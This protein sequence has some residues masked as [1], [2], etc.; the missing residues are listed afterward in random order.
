[1]IEQKKSTHKVPAMSV[2]ER[3]IEKIRRDLAPSDIEVIDESALHAGHAQAPKGGES[4][5]R[6]R[7]VSK[8]FCGLNRIQRQRLIHDILGPELAGPIHALSIDA[9][10]PDE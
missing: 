8:R 10:A 7:V 9:K 2:K 6:I 3:M 1:M 5:F 4:H